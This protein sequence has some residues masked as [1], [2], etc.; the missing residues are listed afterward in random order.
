MELKEAI[1]KRRSIRKYKSED[2][3]N[4]IIEDLIDLARFAP[5]A[6]NRQPWKFMIVRNKVK[7]LLGVGKGKKNYDKRETIKERDLKREAQ[8]MR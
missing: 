8:R 6:K 3:P 2:V 4:N 5:S 7:I 1:I